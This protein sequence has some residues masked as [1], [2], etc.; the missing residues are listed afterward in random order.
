MPARL[1]SLGPARPAPTGP[2]LPPRP[3]LNPGQCLSAPPAAP[4][5]SYSG[6]STIC[7]TRPRL[8]SA[9]YKQQSLGTRFT[10]PPHYFGQNKDPTTRPGGVECRSEAGVAALR[11]LRHQQ[12]S[13]NAGWRLGELT[14]FFINIDQHPAV[15]ALLAGHRRTTGGQLDSDEGPGAGVAGSA[16]IRHSMNTR[17]VGYQGVMERR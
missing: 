9:A 7:T 2:R 13:L 14:P 6:T 17:R 4:V 12:G 1:A 16:L 10:G 11:R 3:A 5:A 15:P 8:L